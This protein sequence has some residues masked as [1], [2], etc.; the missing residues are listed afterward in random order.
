MAFPPGWTKLEGLAYAEETDKADTPRYHALG[1]A[2]T[3]PV[4]EWLAHRV[5][6]YLRAAD[7]PEGHELDYPALAAAI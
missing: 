4:A 1:N 3:P 5:M 2:V 7:E 6:G